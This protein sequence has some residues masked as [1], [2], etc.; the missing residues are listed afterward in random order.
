MGDKVFY[1]TAESLSCIFCYEFF[2]KYKKT[3]RLYHDKIVNGLYLVIY[4]EFYMMFGS[5]LASR[6]LMELFV[7]GVCFKIWNFWT[8]VSRLYW[9]LKSI[10]FT[11]SICRP[12][13][14]APLYIRCTILIIQWH[15]YCAPWIPEV[16]VNIINVSSPKSSNNKFVFLFTLIS[17]KGNN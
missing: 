17:C 6:Y 9:Y 8:S 13:N 10:Y 3:R 2:W 7:L 16:K 1:C 15:F 5:I 4:A 12:V 11:S 14:T